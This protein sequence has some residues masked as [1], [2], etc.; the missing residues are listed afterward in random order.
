VPVLA[1]IR[2][3]NH[4][5]VVAYLALFVALG[6]TAYAVDTIG[7]ADV[8]NDSLK[9]EDI[10]NETL[11][12]GDVALNT[13]ATSRLTDNSLLSVDVKDGTLTAADIQDETLTA[14]DIKNGT[15]GSAD[16]AA[17][18][19]GGGRIADNSLK[20]AD[21]QESSLDLSASGAGGVGTNFRGDPV[22]DPNEGFHG[23]H[24]VTVPS[25]GQLLVQAQSALLGVACKAEGGC[26][27]AFGIYVDGQPVPGTDWTT[28]APAGQATPDFPYLAMGIVDVEPGVRTVAVGRHVEGDPQVERSTAPQTAS[29]YIP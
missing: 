9:S 25:S 2:R 11:R 16:I 28:G 12:G 13:I 15:I 24:T 26:S 4:A 22:A 8:I 5:T 1:R 20:G 6:G 14:A 29:I 18:S 17:N 23:E 21:I 3:P 27:I 7:S 19:L 10:K